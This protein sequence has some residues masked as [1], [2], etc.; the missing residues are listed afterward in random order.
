MASVTEIPSMDGQDEC[1]ERLDSLH[2]SDNVPRSAESFLKAAVSLKNQVVEETGTSGGRGG[3]PIDPTAYTGLLGTAFVLIRLYE[4]TGNPRD[5]LSCAEIIDTCAVVARGSSSRRHVTFLC[6][7]AGVYALGAVVGNYR[8]DLQRRDLFLQLFLEVAQEEALPV[9]PQDGGFGMS[10]DLLHGRAGFLWAAAFINKHIGPDTVPMTLL[11]PVVEAVLAGGRAGA[12]DNV[13]CPLMYRKH[14]TRYWGAVHGL[15]GIL[16][17]LLHFP[18]SAVDAE[19]VKGTLRYMVRNRFPRTGNYPSSE[20]NPRDRLVSW[21]HGATGVAIV[22]CKAAQV[23]P[24]D[25]EFRD[26]AIEAGE[27]VWKEGLV[28]K[29]GLSD[30]VCGNAYAFLSLYRMT[31]ERL[32]LDRAKAFA[33]FLYDNAP[34][35]IVPPGGSI[36]QKYSLFQGLAGIACLMFDM[37]SPENSRFPGFE[38]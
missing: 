36:E 15:A 9:G 14:G 12:L 26:A 37:A 21:A 34:K 3:R 28:T 24:N 30:G 1:I 4:A 31:G 2:V 18:L 6:G 5:L 20:G 13:S 32:Y 11:M 27:V 38:M 25:R 35:L 8:D 19:D 29:V 16:H 33:G 7:R 10:Y 23:F 22:L 17:V